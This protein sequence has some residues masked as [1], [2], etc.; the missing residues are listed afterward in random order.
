[1][2]TLTFLPQLRIVPVIHFMAVKTNL[3]GIPVLFLRWV[4]C[5]TPELE[6]F[7]EQF[8]LGS[9][10][11]KTINIKG[12]NILRST[13]VIPVADIAFQ[14]AYLSRT[15]MKPLAAKAVV[16]RFFM[17]GKTKFILGSLLEGD[18]AIAA[19]ILKFGMFLGKRPGHQ[20]PFKVPVLRLRGQ[21]QKQHNGC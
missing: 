12:D 20:Q 6:V 18:M 10:M 3:R 21:T 2:A 8:K 15:T 19:L 17:A 4:T 1:M 14:F 11:I 16:R 7:A 5:F 9:G 13:L